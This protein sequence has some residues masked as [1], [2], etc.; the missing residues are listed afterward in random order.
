MD[1]LS[2]WA[3][4]GVGWCGRNGL[5]AREADVEMTGMGIIS[6]P[7]FGQTP[8]YTIGHHCFPSLPRTAGLP[9]VI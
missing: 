9:I 4:M 8:G 3:E 1:K 5:Q 6:S 2:T 7:C